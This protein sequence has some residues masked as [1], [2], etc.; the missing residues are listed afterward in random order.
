MKAPAMVAGLLASL[1]AGCTPTRVDPAA[2]LPSVERWRNAE[3]G[4][5]ATDPRSLAA[6]WQ[7]FRDPV[8]NRLVT[9]AL[10]AN[11]DVRAAQARVREAR[12]MV[13]VAESALYPSIELSGSGGREKRIDRIIAVP[14]PQG[15]KLVTPAANA[16]SGGLVARWEIDLFGGRRLEAE[17]AAEQAAGSDEGARAVRVGL[18]ANLATNYLELRALQAR[19][20]ILREQIALQQQRLRTAQALF[21]AGRANR[22]EVAGQQTALRSAEANLPGMLRATEVTI[23]RLGV[24]AGEPPTRLQSLLAPVAPLPVAA[25][26]LP[27]LLPAQLLEQRPDLRLAKRAVNATAAALGAAEAE[28]YP[29]LVLSASGGFGALAVGGYPSLAET[30]YALGSGLSAPLFTAG[31]IRAAITAADARLEQAAADYER[32]FLTALEDV[33]NAYVGHRAAA[34]QVEHWGRAE[35]AASSSWHDAEAF[36]VRG[37]ADL[38]SVLAARGAQ[39]EARDAGVQ[40][41]AALA[42]SVVSLY[43]AFGGGWSTGSDPVASR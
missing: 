31:R 30:V 24:L 9:Q 37:A 16:V 22:G 39:L 5:A 43:R 41:Q 32:A 21:D 6:W 18:L 4:A 27:N 25:P 12:A 36:H 15:V 26:R 7:G 28:R 10:A 23:H 3:A 42:V 29:R 8:L 2:S 14:G 34:E 13:D 19:T 40:A 35:E 38:L 17:A 33:E 1:L 20:G 11:H